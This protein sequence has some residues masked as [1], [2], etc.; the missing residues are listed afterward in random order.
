MTQLCPLYW[1]D[2]ALWGC[3]TEIGGIV[4]WESH[5]KRRRREREGPLD[6][7]RICHTLATSQRL[8]VEGGVPPLLFQM[9]NSE[10]TVVAILLFSSVKVPPVSLRNHLPPLPWSMRLGGGWTDLANQ[11]IST[12]WSSDWFR[13]EHTQFR[14]SQWDS[15]PVYLFCCGTENLSVALQTAGDYLCHHYGWRQLKMEPTRGMGGLRWRVG[16]RET[17]QADSCAN[18]VNQWIALSFHEPF[19]NSVTCNWKK[20]SDIS[21]TCCSQL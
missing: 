5:I 17:R 7:F 11:S 6:P 2:F 8:G 20:T 12:T 13:D 14:L 15:I 21:L 18:S 10:A 19:W 16:E 3:R 9:R 1:T 4:W